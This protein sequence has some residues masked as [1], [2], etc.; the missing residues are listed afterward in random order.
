MDK[1]EVE[2]FYSFESFPSLHVTLLEICVGYAR[3]SVGVNQIKSNV[4]GL[5]ADRAGPDA[6]CAG[7]GC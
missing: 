6:E 2:G 4:R 5:T 1:Q 3:I 7:L